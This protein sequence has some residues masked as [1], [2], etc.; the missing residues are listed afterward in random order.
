MSEPPPLATFLIE[1]L[2][3]T[4][5]ALQGDFS[6]CCIGSSR[7][8]C[9]RQSV[10]II[11]AGIYREIRR[12]PMVAVRALFT[13]IGLAGVLGWLGNRF[14]FGVVSRPVFAFAESTWGRSELNEPYRWLSSSAEIPWMIL[15]G[16]ILTRLYREQRGMAVLLHSIWV[17]AWIG[18]VAPL[19]AGADRPEVLLNLRL[20]AFQKVI[21]VV[22]PLIGVLLDG[23]VKSPDSDRT[24]A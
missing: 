14:W 6:E 17:I 15:F 8:W 2:A 19:I 3:P 16:W 21:A 5:E 22:A 20:F 24:V 13:G 9:W 23:P 1:R 7:S 11:A 12:D 10:W 4:N 18:P